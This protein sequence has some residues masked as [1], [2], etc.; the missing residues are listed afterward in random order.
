MCVFSNIGVILGCTIEV[1]ARIIFA[2][3]LIHTFSSTVFAK[4]IH[5]GWT[6][7]WIGTVFATR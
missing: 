2:Y 7:C 1:I 3:V 4:L 6:A 5:K